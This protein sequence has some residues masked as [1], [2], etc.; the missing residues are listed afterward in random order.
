MGQSRDVFKEMKLVLWRCVG[1]EKIKRQAD[2]RA[3]TCRWQGEIYEWLAHKNTVNGERGQRRNRNIVRKSVCELVELV[4][5]SEVG[6]VL[7][8]KNE[9]LLEH[10]EVYG[11]G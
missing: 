7:L 9:C 11:K 4:N 8:C 1:V 10:A 3:R 2:Y 5:V 6:D